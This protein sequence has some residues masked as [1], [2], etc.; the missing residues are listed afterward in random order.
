MR[1][2]LLDDR[3]GHSLSRDQV[4]AVGKCLGHKIFNLGFIMWTIHLFDEALDLQ[5]SILAVVGAVMWKKLSVAPGTVYPTTCA[6]RV[7][8]LVR[9]LI[10]QCFLQREERVLA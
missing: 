8:E 10:R 1:I 4:T 2:P 7:S 5:S 9:K 3:N 6:P